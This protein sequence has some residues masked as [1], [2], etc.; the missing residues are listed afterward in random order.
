MIGEVPKWC[1]VY[2]GAYTRREPHVAGRSKGIHVMRFNLDSGELTP[3]AVIPGLDNPSYVALHPNGEFLYAANELADYQGKASG[4]VSAFRVDPANRAFEP[5]NQQPSQGAAPCFVSV[6]ADGR[7]VLV[8][9]YGSGNVAVLPLRSDGSLGAATGRVQHSGS[10]V[11]LQRQSAPHPHSIFLDPDNRYALVP[12]LGIDKVMLY[13]Y[14]AESGELAPNCE[15]PWAR[16]KSGAGPRHLAFHPNGVLVF[17]INELDSTITV[18]SYG[19]DRG[20]LT[21]VQTVSTLPVDYEG[22]STGAD[23]HVHPSGHT[24]YA[25]NRGHDSIA[26]YG[27]DEKSGLLALRD[28]IPTEGNHPRGFTVDPLG[29]F[30]LVANQNSDDIVVFAIDSRTGIPRSTGIHVVA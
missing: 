7:N 6:D 30:L 20:T 24:V 23:I 14:D 25:S 22:K 1:W 16:T 9:N 27:V 2:V 3:Y 10:S 4:A 21:E 13:S 17:V 12:D 19:R 8:S 15:Q 5:L 18:F 28:H 29:R 11:H 26:V